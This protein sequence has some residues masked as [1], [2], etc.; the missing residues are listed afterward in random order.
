[1]SEKISLAARVEQT[2]S[3][4]PEE[5]GSPFRIRRCDAEPGT[6]SAQVR[7]ILI[8][9]ESRAEIVAALR[10]QIRDKLIEQA[11]R[12]GIEDMPPLD[13]L[14]WKQ[15]VAKLLAEES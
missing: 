4:T 6:A 15:R 9:E 1:M 2:P 14:R 8:H 12:D 3:Y 11:L 13:R 7:V 5:M 10:H